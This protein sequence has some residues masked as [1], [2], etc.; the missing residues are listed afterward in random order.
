MET[1]D[2][3]PARI[4]APIA[5]IVFGITL[6]VILGSAGGSDHSSSNSGP[7]A[8]ERRDL[9]LKG[10]QRARRRARAATSRATQTVYVVRTG[11]TL[12]A[13]ALRTG[14]SVDQ[15]QQLNPN[16]DPQ[17]LVSGQRIKL[18]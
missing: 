4:V 9:K 10:Q 2:R 7:T 6:L 1:R 12:A 11:D 13:I 15:L 8:A 18:R 14:V 3:S 16:L 5:L 17:A